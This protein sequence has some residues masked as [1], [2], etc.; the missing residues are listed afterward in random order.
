MLDPKAPIVFLPQDREIMDI[1]GM[2]EEDYRWFVRQALVRSKLRP[3]EPV[4]FLDFGISLIIGIALSAAAALLAPKPPERETPREEKRVGGQDFV[5]GQ[6]SA[7]TSG[8]DSVQN[9]VEIGSTIPL[10]YAN[11]RQVGSETYGGVRVNTNLLWS[12][13][14]SIGGGQLLRGIFL[15]GEGTLNEPDPEQFAIGNNLLRNFDLAPSDSSRI[16]VYY[17][18]GSQS[19]NRI[20]SADNIAGRFPDSDLGNAENNGGTDVFEARRP[21]VNQWAPDFVFTRKPSNQTIFGV[22]GFIGNNMPFRLSPEIKPARNFQGV[23]NPSDGE[24]ERDNPQDYSD[25][26]RDNWRYYSRAGVHEYQAAGTDVFVP[27]AKGTQTLNIGDRVKYTIFSSSDFDGQF[28]FQSD[29]ADG[30]TSTSNVA[31]SI[32]SRQNSYDDRIVLGE[33]YL[34][35][36]AQGVCVERS[37]NAFQSETANIPVGG[38]QDVT[39]IFEMTTPGEVDTWVESELTPGLGN[40]PFSSDQFV[41]SAY[42]GYVEDQIN[43]TRNSH[44]LK[45]SE[46]YFTTER[47]TRYVE[48]GLRSSVNLQ[49]NSICYFRN[50]K[51]GGNVRTFQIID[52]D[53][54]DK[55]VTYVNDRLTTPELRISCFR[56]SYRRAQD[57]AFIK[58]PYIFGVR[59]LSTDVVFNYLRFEFTAPEADA[60]AIYEFKLTPLSGYE[61]RNGREGGDPQPLQILDFKEGNRLVIDAGELNVI[62]TG[63]ANVPLGQSTLA[64]PGLTTVNGDPLPGFV[65]IGLAF[66]DLFVE[67]GMD[68]GYFSDAYARVADAFIHDELKASTDQPEHEIVYI[69]T[70]TTNDTAP[71]YGNLAMV[72]LNIRSSTEIQQLQQFSV[73]CN[74]G[75]QSTNNFP[76]VLHDLLTNT[77]Y[78]AGRVLNSQQIDE[79]SFITATTFCENRRYFFDGIISE[80]INLRSWAAE[81]ASNFLLDFVIRNGKFAL[82]PAVDFDNPVQITGLYTSGNITED[83][84]QLSYADEADRIPPRVQVRWREEKPDQQNGLFPITRQVTVFEKDFAD[85]SSPLEQ[86]DLTAYATSQQHAIDLAK[87]I[88]RKKRLITHSVSFSTTPP[89]SSLDIGSVFK[90]GLET[91]SYDQPQNGAIASNGE[92]TSWPPLA[93]GSYQALVWDGSTLEERTIVVVNGKS[94]PINSV[95]C[96]QQTAG[97]TGTYKTQSLSFN[98]DGNIDVQASFYPTDETGLSLIAKDFDSLEPWT[99]EGAI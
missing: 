33:K 80:K 95:F 21:G 4:A 79:S 43:A 18:D 34:I 76:E 11:R 88:C 52:E 81:T 15:V 48:I 55:N 9:V 10:V 31:S 8:F 56:V 94:E 96:L 13:L 77:R 6:R 45:F 42:P 41:E 37:A 71:N 50:I 78:G 85:S 54:N 7:P 60:E 46:A 51:K 82:Q 29:K 1:T 65:G 16:S 3:G 66:D 98:D 20:K 5:S 93:D 83:S 39:A 24:I 75:I 69:N 62:F 87:L 92:V 36:T 74:Q 72:G 22:S 14:L 30:F 12:Q 90:L 68:R 97:Q 35:G 53:K 38:G 73:Y 40:Y 70:Q 89:E 61:V 57:K 99:I 91:L 59:S 17:V 32:A 44:I 27:T 63:L 84:F 25:R 47:K 49:L 64:A 23:Q 19:T 86:I 26:E 58:L 2:S 28:Q 67:P